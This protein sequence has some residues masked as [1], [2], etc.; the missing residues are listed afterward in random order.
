MAKKRDETE[1]KADN[2]DIEAVSVEV[3]NLVMANARAFEAKIQEDITRRFLE[4]HQ[5]INRESENYKKRLK[6]AFGVAAA[7]AAVLLGVVA[8]LLVSARTQLSDMRMQTGRANEALEKIEDANKGITHT[9]EQVEQ[10]R[11]ELEVDLKAML[12]NAAKATD[13]FFKQTEDAR[14]TIDQASTESKLAVQN[15]NLAVTEAR[16]VAATAEAANKQ[17]TTTKEEVDKVLK[18]TNEAKD[19]SIRISTLLK[20]LGLELGKAKPDYTEI[21]KIVRELDQIQTETVSS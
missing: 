4:V 5:R 13:D 1:D 19:K 17:V 11:L 3:S 2:V 16:A 18:W 21:Q 15:A 9:L 7:S 20:R 8:L 6:R 14:K 12:G 10:K